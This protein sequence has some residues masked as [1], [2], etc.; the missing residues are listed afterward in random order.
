MIVEPS[1]PHFTHRP[2]PCRKPSLHNCSSFIHTSPGILPIIWVSKSPAPCTGWIFARM[3]PQTRT[4]YCNLFWVGGWG[5]ECNVCCV[6]PDRIETPNQ[7]TSSKNL[8]AAT[9]QGSHGAQKSKCSKTMNWAMRLG[10][11][12]SNAASENTFDHTSCAILQIA[13]VACR[14]HTT[15][16]LSYTLVQ[17]YFPSLGLAKTQLQ[18]LAGSLQGCTPD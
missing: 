11:S 13:F 3:H 12:S 2:S 6:L 18:A 10:I 16:P 4:T 14:M 8:K 17:E 1:L 9:R 7:N 5:K 15:V